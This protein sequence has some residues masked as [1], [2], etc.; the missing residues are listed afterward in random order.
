MR[1]RKR[2]QGHADKVTQS[3]SIRQR[4]LPANPRHPSGSLSAVTIQRGIAMLQT[5]LKIGKQAK[6][7]RRRP[8]AAQIRE[9]LTSRRRPGM[10]Q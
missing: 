3:K 2:G 8:R 9:R 7:P 4:I 6:S 10:D 1:C 5:V